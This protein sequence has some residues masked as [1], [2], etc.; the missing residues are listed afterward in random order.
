M[1]KINVKNGFEYYFIRS[2]YCGNWHFNW[3]FRPI[4][5]DEFINLHCGEAKTC[6]KDVESLLSSQ[7]KASEY[8]FQR[9]QKLSDMEAAKV[10]LEEAKERYLKVAAPDFGGRGNNPNRDIQTRK[11]AEARLAAAEHQ[12]NT[13]EYYSNVMNNRRQKLNG[14]YLK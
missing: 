2:C 1:S 7:A 9:L 3:Y 13:A 12:L 8:Y 14:D 6:K 5:E 4:G 10:A 11:D